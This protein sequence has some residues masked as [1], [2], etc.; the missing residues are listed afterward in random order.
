MTATAQGTSGAG[1]SAGTATR[2]RRGAHEL[3]PELLLLL[4]HLQRASRETESTGDRRSAEFVMTNHISCRKLC[5]AW[6]GVP[7]AELQSLSVTTTETRVR[8]LST[9]FFGALSVNPDDPS[10]ATIPGT[11]TIQ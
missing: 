3:I 7:R 6:H 8:A 1:K 11:K 9:T 5:M 2:G 4:P 10:L